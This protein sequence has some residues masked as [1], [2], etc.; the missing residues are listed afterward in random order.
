MFFLIVFL[1]A[2]WAGAG[3]SLGIRIFD[4]LESKLK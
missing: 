4:W 1:A 3:F 2:L